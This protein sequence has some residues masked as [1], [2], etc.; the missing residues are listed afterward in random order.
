MNPILLLPIGLVALAALIVPLLIH[1]A[2]RSEQRPTDFAALRW[3]RQRPKPRHRIR[4][5]EWLLLAVRLLLLA[6]LALLLARPALYGAQ[7]DAPWIAVV[8]GVQ[9]QALAALDRPADAR[10]HWLAPG[11]PAFDPAAPAPPTSSE[12][13]VSSLLRELDATLPAQV[14]VTVLVPEQLQGADA[15]RPRLSRQVEWRL[16]PGAMPARNAQAIAVP[17]PSIRYAADRA[18][19]LPYLRAAIASW[20]EPGAVAA[21]RANG[22]IALDTQPLDASS[23]QLMWLKPGP[24]PSAVSEW[25][26]K[27]GTV[28]LDAASAW[29]S[30]EGA[31]IVP[32]PLWRNADGVVLVEGARYGR[33]KVMRWT[34]ALTPQALPELLEPV[35]AGHLRSL[36]EPPREPPSRV[37]AREHAPS[38]G[39]A[40]FVLPPRDLRLWL[41]LLIALVFLVERWLATRPRR[42]AAP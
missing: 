25:I 1:L 13:P 4:F 3:L 14:G 10:M 32:V 24:L 9:V 34:R 37:M 12:L 35:F 28:L 29:P 15:Q 42:G 20:R 41:A 2:R 40:A 18:A 33:G 8:P 30:G 11:F 22:S 23:R 7:S 19:A 5:D 31:A 38:T 39:A 26:A 16:L 36:F 27:G 21:G 6:L 17:D